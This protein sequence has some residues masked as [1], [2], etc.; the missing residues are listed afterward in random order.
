MI[1]LATFLAAS[2]LYGIVTMFLSG[3]L[4]NS[5]AVMA[6]LAGCMI[7]TMMIDIPYGFRTA[8]QIYDLLPTTLLVHWQLWDDRLVPVLGTYLTNFQ[9]AWGIYLITGTALILIGARIYGKAAR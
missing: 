4:K 8:S 1:V 2:V 3:W 9:A 6:I 5:V 7:F